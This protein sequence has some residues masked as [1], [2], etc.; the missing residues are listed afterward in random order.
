MALVRCERCGARGVTRTYV[1][2][3]SPPN[4]PD[5]GLIC[6]RPTC[7]SAGLIWLEQHEAQEYARGERLFTLNTNTAKVRAA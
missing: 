4:H 2:P 1:R 7:S 5:S 3:V 6:G